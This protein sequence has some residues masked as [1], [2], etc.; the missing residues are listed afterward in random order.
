M[1]WVFFAGRFVARFL[2]LEL[3]RLLWRTLVDSHPYSG[4]PSEGESLGRDKWPNTVKKRV[5]SDAI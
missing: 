1:R 3:T 2:S 5:F 4:A